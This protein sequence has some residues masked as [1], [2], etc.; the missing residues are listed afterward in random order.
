MDFYEQAGKMALGSRLRRLSDRITDEAARIYAMYQVELEP[1][2][3]PVFFA[4]S[5]GTEKTITQIAREIGQTH[6]SVSQIVQKM[7]RK[8]LIKEKKD[9][10]GRKNSVMLSDKANEILQKIALQY[11]DV[12]A[13]IEDMLSQTDYNI[14][15]AIAEMEFLLDQKSLLRRVEDQKKTRESQQVKIIS[16]QP[17]YKKDFKE[18]NERW[19]STYFKMEEADH[20]ALD[21]PE[22]YIL[23]K[24]GK[25]LF[26]TYN[27]RIAGTCALIKMDEHTYELAKMAVSPDIQGKGIGY[28]LGKAIIEEAKALG[29]S[30]LYLES[31]TLLKPAIN[32]YHKLGFKKITGKPSPYERSNIQMELSLK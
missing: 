7:T 13:A 3:F 29:A 4:L 17:G 23:N 32:L 18:L 26:A 22:K 10:D 24:G 5:K 12:G 11:E 28:L 14:W 6:P 21:H 2:W 30:T 1:R 16:Y 9:P 25:I 20:K 15:K 19:I 8:G 31:N 27:G